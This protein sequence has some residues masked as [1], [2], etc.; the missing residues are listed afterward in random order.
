M[1]GE[2]IEKFLDLDENVGKEVIGS[3]GVNPVKWDYEGV[4]LVVERLKRLR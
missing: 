3:L 4:R 1:D 2:L